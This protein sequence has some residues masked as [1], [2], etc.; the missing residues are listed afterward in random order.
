MAIAIKMGSGGTKTKEILLWTNSSTSATF[1]GKDITLS[2]SLQNYKYIKIYYS[3]NNN[4]STTNYFVIFP[5]FKSDGTYMF[6]SGD[7]AHRMAINL[8]NNAGN[9]FSRTIYVKDDTTL[10]FNNANRISAS[11]NTNT[12][13]IPWWVYGIK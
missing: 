4:A 3:Y 2:D 13:L 9:S 10:H 12:Y 8:I 1:A 7:E 5:I 6:P 11:G